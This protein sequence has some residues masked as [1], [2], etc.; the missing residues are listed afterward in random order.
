MVR[1]LSQ[2]RLIDAALLAAYAGLLAL[3]TPRVMV[4][5]ILASILLGI[6]ASWLTGSKSLVGSFR[7]FVR[8][9][10][11]GAMVIIGEV[12]FALLPFV[13]APS[14][15]RWPVLPS[16]NWPELAAALPVTFLWLW[17][18]ASIG[19]RFQEHRDQRLIREYEA[20]RSRGTD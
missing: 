17:L 9:P 4:Q 8:Y 15:F 5:Y 19:T 10:Y 7:W 18:F 11:R 6:A 12:M 3:F 2:L 13:I 16:S 20:K 1:T 14:L